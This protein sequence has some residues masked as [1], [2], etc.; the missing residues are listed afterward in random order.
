MATMNFNSE[1]ETESKVLD[2]IS[3]GIKF[4]VVGRKSIVI[5]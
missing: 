3:K 5:L 2:L 4:R 1:K